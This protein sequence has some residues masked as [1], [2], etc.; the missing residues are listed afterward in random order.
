MP[1][2]GRVGNTNS[3]PE[4]KGVCAVRTFTNPEK[5]IFRERNFIIADVTKDSAGAALGGCTVH[6]FNAANNTLEQ[7]AISD[8][9]G[10]YSFVVDKTKLYFTRAYKSGAPDVAGTSVNT[11]AGA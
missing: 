8:A 1:I 10:N 2:G 7:T 6:L 3:V 5:T 11:L 9:A 4:V